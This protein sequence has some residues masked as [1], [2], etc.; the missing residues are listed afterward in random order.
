MAGSANTVRLMQD[1]EYH[2][3]YA[4]KRRIAQRESTR[5]C[6]AKK[7]ACA[8]EVR[9]QEE[10]AEEECVAEER[11]LLE[12]PPLPTLVQGPARAYRI[13]ADIGREI[14]EFAAS[15]LVHHDVNI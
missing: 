13:S 7:A 14:A 8:Q 5:R 6:R 2:A 12:S 10:R 4:E 3:M 9:V 1:E 15:R 11:D